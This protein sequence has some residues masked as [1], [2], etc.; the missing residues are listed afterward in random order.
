MNQCSL[1]K[2]VNVSGKGLHTGEIVN[3]VIKPA[4]AN[5]GL[6]F[7][8]MDLEG[9]P[10]IVAD[11]NNVSFTTRNTTIK[12]GNATVSTIE[13]LLSALYAL[14]V[15]NAL[16][17]IDGPEVPIKDGSSTV[18]V[19]A[20]L[21][22]G[23]DDLKVEREVLVITSPI[24]YKDEETNSEISVLP[25]DGFELTALIDF[26]SELLGMQY[27]SYNGYTDYAKDVA[28]SR[29]FVFL[30]ELTQL[31]QYDLVKGGGLDNAVVFVETIPE[32]EEL[33]K[34]ASS[35]GEEDVKVEAGGILNKGGLRFENEPARHKLLDMIGDL[36]LVGKAIQGR[37]VVTK[38]GHTANVNLAK[39]LKALFRKQKKLKGIPKYDPTLSPIYD[40][41]E[42][43]KKLPHRFPFLLIDKIIELSERHVVGIKNV[44]FNEGFFQGHFP[45]NPVMPGVLQIEAMAQTGGILALSTVPDPENWD[46]YF[47]KIDK[48]KFKK[49][50]IPG[51]TLIFK[52]E[53]LAPI[54]RGIVS[55]YGVAYVGENIVSEAELTA[56]IVRRP[57]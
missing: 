37:I 54:R 52:L 20:I 3:L 4:A 10:L 56:Q 51:D 18:F 22:A 5:Y 49:K 14:G 42:I 11:A 39:K 12:K 25:A 48:A 30:H 8:R 6:R 26:G 13:H 34:I 23:I 41:V 32:E 46:T 44:T 15:D 7:Q 19:E 36:A 57:V 35:F 47:L 9:S 21:E 2:A 16:I 43:T 29:T 17:E 40:V 27:A 31:L 53:L 38:P 55:M 1:K 24:H 33:K 28:P 45:D 50:V